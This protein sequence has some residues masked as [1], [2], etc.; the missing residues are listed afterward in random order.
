MNK[1]IDKTKK[2]A[3]AIV[4]D[5][6]NRLCVW[7]NSG[8]LPPT[9]CINAF[10]C[11]NCPLDR[12]LKKDIA[13]GALKDGRILA[14][15]R[16]S[17]D[18]KRRSAARKK[19]R[20]MLSGRVSVK[21]CINDYDC[22]RC[23]YHQ[24]VEEEILAEQQ[25]AAGHSIVSGFALAHNHYYHNG[26]TWAR[27]EYGGFVRIGLDDFALKIFGPVDEFVLPGLGRVVCQNEPGFGFKRGELEANCRCPVEG[28]VVAVNQRAGA[29]V[30]PPKSDAYDDGWLLVVEPVKLRNNLR[31]LFYGEESRLW[32]EDEASRLTSMISEEAEYRLAAT[33]GRALT[34]IYGK[35]PELGWDRLK[36]E[37]LKS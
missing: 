16:V 4:Y 28:V 13:S 3:Q 19:C 29:S 25:S 32:L 36:E 11:L 15:W 27:V 8:V 21:Y 26:H 35:M 7:S 5:I 12:K 1:Q 9:V 18:I 33:G 2:Q 31:N 10:D 6:S 14:G 37:F 34:D 17:G 30:N 20:H 24:M 23:A 22:E